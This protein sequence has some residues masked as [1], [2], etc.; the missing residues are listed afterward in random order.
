MGSI[1]EVFPRG[2]NL[3]PRG[4]TGRAW[5]AAS[6]RA[7]EAPRARLARLDDLAAIRALQ[8]A[9]QPSAPSSTPRQFEAR[10]RA[11][12]EGQLV[13]ERGCE[14]LASAS[15]L[16]VRWDD[17][18]PSTFDT[19]DPA[20]HTLLVDDVAIDPEA[21]GDVALRRLLQAER[22]LCRA[23][24]LRRIILAAR[25]PGYRDFEGEMSPEDYAGRVVW[26]DIAEAA[27][28]A[29]LALGFQYCGIARGLRP[30]DAESCGHAALLAWLNPLFSPPQPPA[31]ERPRKCA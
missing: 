21:P 24:N 1:I 25:I 15:A 11:F 9:A 20:G 14:L 16:I 19:H 31:F 30:A 3:A 6:A 23:L 7:V 10:R 28:R 2:S 18:A 4:N 8:H 13:V 27:L 17:P 29:P 22:R 12:P 26:G 5:R